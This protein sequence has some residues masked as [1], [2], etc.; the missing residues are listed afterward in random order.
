MM[1][2]MLKLELDFPWGA[3]AHHLVDV[4]MI[5]KPK[6]PLKKSGSGHGSTKDS[7]P[8][9]TATDKKPERFCGTLIKGKNVHMEWI[10]HFLTFVQFVAR[11]IPGCNTKEQQLRSL[12]NRMNRMYCK[13]PLSK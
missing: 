3:D 13:I 4:F 7:K 12:P 5:E 9:S 6:K 2:K 10:A 11:I 8:K 1:R